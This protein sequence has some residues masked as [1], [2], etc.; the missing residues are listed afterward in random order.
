MS[1]AWNFGSGPITEYMMSAPS[2]S[3]GMRSEGISAC[4]SSSC[5]CSVSIHSS[6]LTHIW[7]RVAAW[8]WAVSWM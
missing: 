6:S 2:L 8:L 7:L 3:S 1:W 5:H 4:A